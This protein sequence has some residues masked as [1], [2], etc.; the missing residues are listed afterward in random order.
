MMKKNMLPDK[1]G[2]INYLLN[3]AVAIVWILR[4]G[5]RLLKYPFSRRRNH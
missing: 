1:G 5:I 2:V 3:F 4:W